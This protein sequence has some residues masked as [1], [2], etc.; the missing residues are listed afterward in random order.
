MCVCAGTGRCG[1][2]RK[3]YQGEVVKFAE[4]AQ[5]PSERVVETRDLSVAHGLAG[6]RN[7]MNISSRR[8]QECTP[9]GQ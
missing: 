2:Y 8:T 1:V 6:P 3:P 9:R 5:I 4:A 7:L